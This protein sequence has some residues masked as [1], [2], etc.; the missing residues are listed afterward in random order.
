MSARRVASRVTGMSELV[1]L[2]GVN[3]KKRHDDMLADVR[4][5]PLLQHLL[6]GPAC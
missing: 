4:K 6:G 2:G 5:G 1:D 3:L